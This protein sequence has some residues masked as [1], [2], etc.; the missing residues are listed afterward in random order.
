MAGMISFS[1][2]ILGATSFASLY[3][4]SGLFIFLLSAMII[5][6]L[7]RVRELRRL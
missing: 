7:L 2:V 5:A 1:L 3:G 6:L 4:W